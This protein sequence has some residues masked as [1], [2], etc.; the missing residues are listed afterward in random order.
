MK[1][2]LISAR[3]AMPVEIYVLDSVED[4]H[5][6]S[7]IERRIKDWLHDQIIDSDVNLL[8]MHMSGL[9]SAVTSFLKMW[10]WA[11]HF[12]EMPLLEI[13]HYDRDSDSYL[14]QPW[15]LTVE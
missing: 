15:N 8:V 13:A 6:Y 4:V 11:C 12:H 2:G 9:G 10:S 3:H 5:D 7:G 14:I 1:A